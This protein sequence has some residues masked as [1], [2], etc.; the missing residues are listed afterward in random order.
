MAYTEC[1]CERSA[2]GR[3][4]DIGRR[5]WHASI[6]V[7]TY[8]GE[9][10]TWRYAGS[11]V[12]ISDR[13]LL[14]AN[15]LLEDDLWKQVDYGVR[16]G[17]Q[18]IG[19][20]GDFVEVKRILAHPNFNCAR[21]SGDLC[22]IYLRKPIEFSENVQPIRLPQVDDGDKLANGH[23]YSASGWLEPDELN[24]CNDK[25][26]SVEQIVVQNLPCISDDDA[27]ATVNIKG[28][29]VSE[30]GLLFL[31][32]TMNQQFLFRNSQ[33]KIGCPLIRSSMNSSDDY[34]IGYCSAL[35]ESRDHTFRFIYTNVAPFLPWLVAHRNWGYEEH[36]IGGVDL[37]A[38]ASM[39][40]PHNNN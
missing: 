13:L 21:L 28:C 14:T 35:S 20:G 38:E 7:G 2:F 9:F 6:H 19:T 17:S 22:L 10:T 33:I 24:A 39:V 31:R 29:P 18:Q 30:F 15:N 37:F 27:A 11:A 3:E 4:I 12:I 40:D 8:D 25:L 5:P 1:K 16:I 26:Q 36:P 34:L 23:S 32:N